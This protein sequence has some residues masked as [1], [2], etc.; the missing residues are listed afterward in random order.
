MYVNV[1]FCQCD[2]VIL[3]LLFAPSLG[4]HEVDVL[5]ASHEHMEFPPRPAIVM[6]WQLRIGRLRD[7]SMWQRRIGVGSVYVRYVLSSEKYT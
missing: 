1:G 6:L 4:S 3:P 2:L 7:L 5:L